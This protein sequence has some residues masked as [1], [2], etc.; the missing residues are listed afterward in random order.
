MAGRQG[1]EPRYR[2]PESG[3]GI[4]VDFDPLCFAPVLS[5]PP[6]LSAPFRF[7]ALPRSLSLCV[8]LVRAE[9]RNRSCRRE[10]TDCETP[11]LL[12]GQTNRISQRSGCERSHR[13]ELVRR[14]SA[15]DDILDGTV[16][17]E[18]R[19]TLSAPRPCPGAA[20]SAVSQ[21]GIIARFLITPARFPSLA[22]RQPSDVGDTV[23]G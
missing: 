2:G 17:H 6:L 7:G 16:S 21:A 13:P 18:D 23:V 14:S 22:N 19:R 12:N 10:Q 8:S 4:L 3:V 20:L 15:I 1:F 9:T 5:D 11:D